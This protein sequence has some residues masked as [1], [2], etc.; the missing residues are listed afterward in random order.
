MP[1]DTDLTSEQIREHVEKSIKDDED[2]DLISPD[3][4]DDEGDLG[5]DDDE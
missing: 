4:D 3:D 2:D 1:D 5:L